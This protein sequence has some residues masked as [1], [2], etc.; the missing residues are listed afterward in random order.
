MNSPHT[1]QDSR[2]IPGRSDLE[3]ARSAG[4]TV[5]ALAEVN[6]T[7]LQSLEGLR[8][9]LVAA[10]Q[11]RGAGASP[12]ASERLDG[13]LEFNGCAP[14]KVLQFKTRW[15]STLSPD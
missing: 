13:R 5:K 9:V 11:Q 12:V 7:L 14:D 15:L 1:Q 8:E 3:E 10:S 6:C 4:S 2:Q